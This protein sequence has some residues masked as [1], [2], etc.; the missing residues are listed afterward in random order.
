M[1]EMLNCRSGIGQNDFLRS[2]LGFVWDPMDSIP[3]S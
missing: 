1:N 3:D 2:G